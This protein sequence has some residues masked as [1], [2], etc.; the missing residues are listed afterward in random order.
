MTVAARTG[1]RSRTCCCVYEAVDPLGCQAG[2]ATPRRPL[3]LL[4][5]RLPLLGRGAAGVE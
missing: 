2:R 5:K 4:L 1:S 3:P